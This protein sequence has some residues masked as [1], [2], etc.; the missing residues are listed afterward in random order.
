[1]YTTGAKKSPFD[2]RD[3][4]YI[5]TT[6][7]IKGGEKWTPEFIDEQHHVGIC[8]AISQTMRAKKFYGIDFSPEF[9]YLM[10][11]RSENNWDEGSSI[12]SALTIGKNVGFLPKSEWTYTTDEDRKLPYN[13]YIEKLKAI[14]ESEI[15][16]LISLVGKYK[17]SV[18][19]NIP[20][21][22]DNIA[23]GIDNEGALLVRF[24]LD[25]HWW[26]PPVE[27]LQAPVTPISGHAINLTNYNGNSFRVANS[28]GIG[29]VD[30]G[31]AYFDL[32]T[33][34]PTEAWGV[35]YKAIPEVPT[36]PVVP[37]QVQKQVENRA[38]LV[39][40]IIDMLQQIIALVFQLK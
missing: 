10:Q 16:R 9:Q 23:N 7:N 17:I 4:T 30:S 1:M 20:I 3:F 13:Q 35:W 14:P 15:T 36:I 34:Q 11:K 2:I 29:W 19:A 32:A 39:G 40:K 22:R 5:P 24:D 37:P 8:T 25:A 33:Y 38:T 18:Y 31:T 6:A 21:T 26:T 27:P 12:R 28:W